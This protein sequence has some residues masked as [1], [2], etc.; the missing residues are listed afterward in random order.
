[1]TTE[2]TARISSGKSVFL[3]KSLNHLRICKVR[4]GSYLKSALVGLQF[5]T[6]YIPEEIIR[7]LILPLIY[8]LV[9]TLAD[10]IDGTRFLFMSIIYTTIAGFSGRLEAGE[11]TKMVD[12]EVD[13]DGV[14]TEL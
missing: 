10:L 12:I 11:T 13:E 1:M 5:V 9:A 7:V 4:E 2:A 8:D 6:L 14:I 3:L